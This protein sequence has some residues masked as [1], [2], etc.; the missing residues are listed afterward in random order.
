M[1]MP[2]PAPQ[3]YSGRVAIVTGAARG[4]GRAIAERL[5]ERGAAVA[6]N[7]RDAGRA[8]TLAASLGE[9]ALALPGDITDAGVPRMIVD[10]TLE[11][12]GRID[13]LVNNAAFAR[14]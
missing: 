6:I 3:D 14:S 11:R 2:L 8:N 9:R 7:V 13:I 4:L 10:H 1:P 12:F 5:H